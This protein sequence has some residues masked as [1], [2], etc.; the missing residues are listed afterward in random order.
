M[1]VPAPL[2]RRGALL[3]PS[4]AMS[5]GGPD[6]SPAL[7]R[8][9][10]ANDEGTSHVQRTGERDAEVV[11]GRTSVGADV[12]AGGEVSGRSADDSAPVRAHRLASSAAAGE[13]ADSGLSGATAEAR[14]PVLTERER[15]AYRMGVLAAGAIYA[16][17]VSRPAD[18]RCVENLRIAI[19]GRLVPCE[20]PERW[21][22]RGDE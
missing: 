12:G 20:A 9:A 8:G 1:R 21:P 6:G 17:A 14:P 5:G 15:Q 16:D 2:R 4:T 11:E 10:Q 19:A 3:S 18:R 13:S 22:T 7:E